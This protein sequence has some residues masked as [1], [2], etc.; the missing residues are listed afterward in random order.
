M[1]TAAIID[2]LSCSVAVS[3]PLQP[4]EP[5]ATATSRRQGSIAN[6]TERGRAHAL[7]HEGTTHAAIAR[8][9]G[10]LLGLD[11]LDHPDLR[12][13]PAT[14]CYLVPSDTLVDIER[15]QA[16]GVFSA[17]DLFGAVVP[18]SFIAT[19]AITHPIISPDAVA[20]DGWIAAFAE[21]VR[22]AVLSGLAAFSL[23]DARRAGLLLLEDGPVRLKSVLGVGGR[24]QVTVRD[25]SA[26]DAAL[27]AIDP[28]EIAGHGLVLEEN[29]VDVVTLSVGQVQ[30]GG[31]TASYHGSQRLTRDHRGELVYGGSDLHVVRGGFDTLLA[32]DLPEHVRLAIVQARRYDTAAD[33]LFA[34]FFASRRN[35]DV[36]QGL[37][38]RGEWRSGVLEQSWRIGGA[39]GA[40]VAAL[41]AFQADPRLSSVQAST[42][43]CYG[44]T[45]APAGAIVSFDGVDPELGQI[46]KYTVVEPS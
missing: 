6:Y 29:L 40:E 7:G 33:H 26:L 38:G 11:Y 19:K 15:A 21:Q 24:G 37:N 22:D 18:H 8:R 20:P 14:G 43:E 39:S 46:L 36:A 34:G 12:D 27:A 16:L 2:S 10:A 17:D 13:R 5:S 4:A 35:Y 31:M 32:V 28:Q 41:E 23:D 30:V 45:K 25:A 1:T 44:G 3:V 9:L 42:F